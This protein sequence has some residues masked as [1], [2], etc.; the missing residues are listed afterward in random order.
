MWKQASSAGRALAFLL[1]AGMLAGCAAFSGQ[2]AKL[3]EL[4]DQPYRIQEG[5]ELEISLVGRTDSEFKNQVQDDGTFLYPLVGDLPVVGLSL[6]ELEEEISR[7][8]Q[9]QNAVPAASPETVETS[10]EFVTPAQAAHHLYVLQAGDQL[11]ITVWD[12]EDISQ[13]IQIRDDGLFQYPLIGEIQAAGRSIPEVEREIR[14]RLNQDYIV[15][16][17]VTV[18]LSGAQFSVL[19]QKGDSGLFPIDGTVDLLTAISKAGD[20]ST[21]RSS[22]V[23]II[24]RQGGKQVTIRADVDRILSGKEINIPVLPRDTLYIKLISSMDT[25]LRFSAK[26]LNA[27]F[28]IL[29][30]V[31]SPG[32]YPIEGNVDLLAAISTAGGITKFGSSQVEVIRTVGDK[33]VVLS[34]NVDRVLQGRQPNLTILPRDT[35]YVKRRLF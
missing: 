27:R 19:G 6:R 18:R 7:K 22:R 26:V 29:G 28:T 8:V 33:K 9:A 24:R 2:T 3:E 35:L 12:H 5:D 23:E 20:I 10:S 14:D 15:E 34:A 21:L 25:G 11:D 1:A 31:T 17:Q 30:E 4:A 13:K 16:P 32:A